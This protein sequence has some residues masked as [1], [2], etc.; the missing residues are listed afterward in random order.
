VPLRTP[1]LIPTPV[2]PHDPEATPE[3]PPFE[4]RAVSSKHTT[5][6]CP[7]FASHTGSGSPSLEEDNAQHPYKSRDSATS[8]Y[9]SDPRTNQQYSIKKIA[10]SN[11]VL[12][13]PDHIC[14]LLARARRPQEVSSDP[15]SGFRPR[16]TLGPTLNILTRPSIL[17]G[18][19]RESGG[20]SFRQ[21][22]GRPKVGTASPPKRD[23]IVITSG[24][25]DTRVG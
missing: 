4:S 13:A 24:M 14:G 20:R 19:R 3:R 18:V 25:E 8:R 2:I 11:P 5:R 17:Y 15:C 9:T 23:L 12:S 22:Q 21:A 7:H 16:Q 10:G 6:S 1:R